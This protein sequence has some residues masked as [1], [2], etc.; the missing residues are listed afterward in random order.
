MKII[1]LVLT[2]QLVFS[3]ASPAAQAARIRRP[4]AAS[5]GVNYGFDH[6]GSAA[7]CVDY[8]CGGVCYNTH[9]GTDFPLS[10][11]TG[12]LA[13]APGRDPSRRTRA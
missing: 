6:N 3:L 11:G 13:T 10:L 2:L 1:T 4:F 12:V 9:T 5:I 8:G 7:G